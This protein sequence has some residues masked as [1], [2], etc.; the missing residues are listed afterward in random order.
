MF[1]IVLKKLLKYFLLRVAI[2]LHS[3]LYVFIGVLLINE[4]TGF[5]PKHKILNYG[6]WFEKKVKPEWSIVDIGSGKG[7]L[8]YH[9][10]S[11][12][13]KVVGI[14]IDSA[15]YLLSKKR[16][17]K[18][19]L[20]WV[21]ADAM[22]VDYSE[23]GEIDAVILSNVLEHIAKREAFINHLEANIQWGRE[24]PRFL[25]RVPTIERDWLSV[26]K[27]VNGYEYRLDRTHFIEYTEDELRA[28][29][30]NAGLKTEVIERRFDELFLVAMKHS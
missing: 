12:V 16:F 7:V 15:N 20:H 6:A 28:E 27:F 3:K 22:L 2:W 30:Q 26:Y 18:E 10:A 5:H 1:K 8:G 23:L 24:G 17:K 14:E 29:I 9:L 21:H 4:K 13:K 25:I 19:N 11:H